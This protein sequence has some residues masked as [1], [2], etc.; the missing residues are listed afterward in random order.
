MLDPSHAVTRAV[1]LEVEPINQA[2][3]ALQGFGGEVQIVIVPQVIRARSGPAADRPGPRPA[4]GCLILLAYHRQEC[5]RTFQRH[6]ELDHAVLLLVGC[7]HYPLA[8]AACRE[9]LD[10]SAGD[11]RP[12]EPDRRSAR[13]GNAIQQ[14]C[15]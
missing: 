2:P 5:R 9:V 10:V 15:R 6:A 13:D 11:E 7:V 12:V 4:I 14:R 1:P 8:V 3:G